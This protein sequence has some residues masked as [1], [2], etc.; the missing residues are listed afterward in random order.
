[1]LVN[2]R[3]NFYAQRFHSRLGPLTS[4]APHVRT[5][6]AAPFPTGPQQSYASAPSFQPIFRE[7]RAH[8]QS[9]DSDDEL[10]ASTFRSRALSRMSDEPRNSSAPQRD[11]DHVPKVDTFYATPKPSVKPAA[12]RVPP[13]AG[14]PRA[15]DYV[16]SAPESAASRAGPQTVINAPLTSLDVLVGNSQLTTQPK[17]NLLRKAAY[18]TQENGLA[19]IYS[20]GSVSFSSPS[21]VCAT[22]LLLEITG[23]LGNF[24][25]YSGPAGDS[26]FVAFYAGANAIF[27]HVTCWADYLMHGT[28]ESYEFGAE[29]LHLFR[30]P[31]G[32]EPG[33]GIQLRDKAKLRV[34]L[35]NL[36]LS[37]LQKAGLRHRFIVRY[38]EEK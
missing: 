7:S 26:K 34:A 1:M 35:Q 8:S 23:P 24:A 36:D 15:S 38:F 33:Q 11:W 29:Q 2:Q 6:K 13:T 9:W 16:R 19:D 31:L 32:H 37:S 27:A 28:L 3:K 12:P 10:S 22:E 20:D 5:P 30:M 4:V 14:K 17:Q 18:L 21:A 25:E